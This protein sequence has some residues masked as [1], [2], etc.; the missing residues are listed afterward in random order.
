[1]LLKNCKYCGIEFEDKTKSHCK[2]FCS[3]RHVEAY[4][5]T[6]K[7]EGKILEID[8]ILCPICNQKMEEITVNHA[9]LHRYKT[10]TEL[11]TAF[12][13]KVTKCQNRCEKMKG[14]G[15]P[16][17]QHRGK[18]SPWSDKSKCHSQEQIKESKIRQQRIELELVLTKKNL[19]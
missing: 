8:Y 16:G 5:F 19:G 2:E 17:Y 3:P 9:R 4:R 14:S 7:F 12:G 11:A 13:M 6:R 18:L 1:M 10:P 15:N